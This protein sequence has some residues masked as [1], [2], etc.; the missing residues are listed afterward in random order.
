MSQNIPHWTS[1]SYRSGFRFQCESFSPSLDSCLHPPCRRSRTYCRNMLARNSSRLFLSH[2]CSLCSRLADCL[3]CNSRT[4]CLRSA[5]AGLAGLRFR[6]CWPI[7]ERC[8][9]RTWSGNRD[10]GLMASPRRDPEEGR[11]SISGEELMCGERIGDEETH[12]EMV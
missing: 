6:R 3:L 12:S 4:A 7:L 9:R 1:S 11:G 8:C 2:S 5:F 10:R